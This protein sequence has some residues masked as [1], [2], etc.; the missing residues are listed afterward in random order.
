M[1]NSGD[2][3]RPRR[4]RAQ[5]RPRPPDRSQSAAP[6]RR[7]AIPAAAGLQPIGSPPIV[8]K[9]HLPQQQIPPPPKKSRA[10]TAN[11]SKRARGR[12]RSVFGGNS[13]RGMRSG[14]YRKQNWALSREMA[15]YRGLGAIWC[16]SAIV[17]Q[18]EKR[19]CDFTRPS[20][21]RRAA[22]TIGG[23]AQSQEVKP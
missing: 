21:A 23:E 1:Q 16:F 22:N 2:R 10:A 8:V 4:R 20:K 14:F 6:R 5:S 19:R 12:T 13:R 15:V 18:C 9:R 11:D 17:C 3:R 7:R